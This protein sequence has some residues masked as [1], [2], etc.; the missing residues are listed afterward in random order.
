MPFKAKT[1]IT[2]TAPLNKSENAPLRFHSCQPR[3]FATV[4]AA[5]LTAFVQAMVKCYALAKKSDAQSIASFE[6]VS[7]IAAM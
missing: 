5:C 3:A 4:D 2:P 1:K 7:R 6:K